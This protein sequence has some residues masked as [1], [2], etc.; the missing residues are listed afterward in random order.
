MR[1][2][3]DLPEL[4]VEQ[5]IFKAAL[6]LVAE[7]AKKQ[8]EFDFG[9]A[10]GQINKVALGIRDWSR[11]WNRETTERLKDPLW[12][13]RADSI[14]RI[15]ALGKSGP[16]PLSTQEVG[17]GC[18][19]IH[20]PKATKFEPCD[21]EQ[22]HAGVRPRPSSREISGRLI[23]LEGCCAFEPTCNLRAATLSFTLLEDQQEAHRESQSDDHPEC[24][25]SVPQP[26]QSLLCLLRDCR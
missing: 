1:A 7:L 11:Q 23:T 21:V 17:P 8:T 9:S 10:K 20:P 19:V 26:C 6:G 15:A 16:D 22:I 2:T 5:T 3:Q 12:R 25:G 18:R 24:S 4:R 14:Q 13:I